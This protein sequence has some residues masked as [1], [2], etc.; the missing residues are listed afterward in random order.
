MCTRHF[1]M[2]FFKVRANQK[3]TDVEVGEVSLSYKLE[4]KL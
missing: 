4:Q 2:L 3:V 1:V